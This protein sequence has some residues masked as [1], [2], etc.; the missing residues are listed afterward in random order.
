MRSFK[1]I[2]ESSTLGIVITFFFVKVKTK[3][4]LTIKVIPLLLSTIIILIRTYKSAYLG[5]NRLWVIYIGIKFF[6]VMFPIFCY[7]YLE[8]FLCWINLTFKVFKINVW[9][10]II[11]WT[12]CDVLWP[13]FLSFIAILVS[14]F[15]YLSWSV[16]IT[17][18]VL[19]H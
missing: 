4:P 16:L 9:G 7:V 11:F 1:I 13:L 8:L 18:F 17:F 19:T 3:K 15:Y 12:F 2:V 5:L 6:T 10:T 14:L